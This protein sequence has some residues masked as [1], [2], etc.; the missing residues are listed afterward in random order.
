MTKREYRPCWLKKNGDEVFQENKGHSTWSAF[1]E[2][3]PIQNMLFHPFSLTRKQHIPSEIVEKLMLA[4]FT[5]PILV[6]EDRV[7]LVAMLQYQ[8]QSPNNVD[9]QQPATE[10]LGDE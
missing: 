6:F 8:M 10:N 9:L 4:Q 5:A 7:P 2:T 3:F 1:T